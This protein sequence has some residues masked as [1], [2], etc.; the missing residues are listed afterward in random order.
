MK[1]EVEK[2]VEERK[3]LDFPKLMESDDSLLVLLFTSPSY[4]TVVNSGNE[5][6]YELGYI[7]TDWDMLEFRDFEGKIILEN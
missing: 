1:S 3:P 5:S 4:G 2:K 7:A 6:L